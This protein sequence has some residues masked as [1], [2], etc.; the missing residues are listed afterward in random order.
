VVPFV[1]GVCVYCMEAG[2]RHR[3][4]GVGDDQIVGLGRRSR[5][6]LS[7]HAYGVDPALA[8]TFGVPLYCHIVIQPVF[9]LKDEVRGPLLGRA[10]GCNIQKLE[11][12]V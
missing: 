9:S 10:V 6:L 5:I 2:S 11:N 3:S 7:I 1:L 4:R 12:C 8:Y